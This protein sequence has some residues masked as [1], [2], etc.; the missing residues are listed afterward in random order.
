M[1]QIEL[2]T[3][4]TSKTVAFSEAIGFHKMSCMGNCGFVKM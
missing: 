4:D 3:D 1:R 2:V